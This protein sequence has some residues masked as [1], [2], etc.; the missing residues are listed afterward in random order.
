[1]VMAVPNGQ[2]PSWPAAGGA[3]RSLSQQPSSQQHPPP[4]LAHFQHA[5]PHLRH[6]TRSLSQH[7]D[8]PAG[9][10]RL[11]TPVPPDTSVLS[12]VPEATLDAEEEGR[13]AHFADRFR[14]SEAFIAHLFCEDG[15]YNM[16]AIQSWQRA[17]PAPLLPPATDPSPA[18]EPPRKKVK[19]A[20][21]EDDY[22]DDEDEEEEEGGDKGGEEGGDKK[23][24]A[25]AGV[26]KEDASKSAAAA[27]SLLSPSKSGSSPV[28]SVASPDRN[29]AAKGDSDEDA[30]KRLEQDR[31]AT[32][33]RVRCSFFTEFHTLEYDHTAMLEQQ[34]LEEAEKQLLAE[35]ETINAAQATAAAAGP[36][37]SSATTAAQP[38]AGHGTLS[39]ANLGASSLTLKHLIAR[40][41]QKRDQVRA[42]DAELRLLMNEV[43][44]NRSKW[45]SEENVNQE[46]LYEA[47]DK[48]LS[49]LKAHTEAQPF[50]SRVNK[51]DAP[52]YYNCGFAVCLLWTR[53]VSGAAAA[54]M[55][56]WLVQWAAP[57]WVLQWLTTHPPHPPQSS[58]P[59]WTSAP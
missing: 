27:A 7:P 50:M 48:V 29:A 19:R 25:A 49:E 4:H 15:T 39:S 23:D 6:A 22:D 57:L 34:Q 31:T 12:L 40:I 35:M 51:R 14:K 46:E 55:P 53:G 54:C 5:P 37:E 32:E 26:V 41:D 2:A 42:S 21:D 45:A 16:P 18:Q 11:A 56:V 38:G 58:K 10:G 44:K 3:A 24:A 9:G 59:P 17:P 43:R 33:Q 8:D 13:R 28:H 20:I 47:F 52:D 30:R 36:Q 1:M